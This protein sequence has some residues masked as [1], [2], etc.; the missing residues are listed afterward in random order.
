M[1]PNEP[2]R[3]WDDWAS[4]GCEP[5]WVWP[6]FVLDV[7]GDGKLS[8]EE[9]VHGMDRMRP[10]PQPDDTAAT[11]AFTEEMQR[12]LDALKRHGGASDA[13][14]V[15]PTPPPAPPVT[16]DDAYGGGAPASADGS[17]TAEGDASGDAPS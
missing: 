14:S 8:L 4:D 7:S 1:S 3:S 5:A 16:V 17:Y 15:P 6:Q 9:W 10:P 2:G 13:A 12:I 11:A